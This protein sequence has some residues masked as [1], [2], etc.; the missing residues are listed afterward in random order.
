MAKLT[1]SDFM[2]TTTIFDK[3]KVKKSHK[4]LS[5]INFPVRASVQDQ[6]KFTDAEWEKLEKELIELIESNEEDFQKE[7]NKEEDIEEE[8]FQDFPFDEEE[9][10]E[11][12][13][14]FPFN[15]EKDKEK[16]SF[17]SNWVSFFL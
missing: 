15:E 4:G 9:E 11:V 16:K 6:G 8:A 14:D 3:N 2:F 12:F 1:I 7:E 17:P 13:Q 5:N 10:E